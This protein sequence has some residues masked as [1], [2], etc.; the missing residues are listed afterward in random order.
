LTATQILE[1]AADEAERS[2]E[3]YRELLRVATVWGDARELRRAADLLGGELSG[4]GLDVQLPDSG[5]PG[6]PML[7]ARLPGGPGPTLLLAGHMEVYPPSQSWTLDPWAATV[8]D[9]RVYGNVRG[10][11]RS[12][13]RWRRAAG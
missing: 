13:P 2:L 12:W 7:I 8:R 6:M 3:L 10:G 5:T 4:A 11:R 1:M 9:G